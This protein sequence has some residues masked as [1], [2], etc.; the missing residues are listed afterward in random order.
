MLRRTN[1]FSNVQSTYSYHSLEHWFP[2]N[3]NGT[4][5]SS[6]TAGA[7]PPKKHGPPPKWKMVIVVT[8][9][10]YTQTLWIPK[11]TKAIFPKAYEN[12]NVK[13]YAM[14]LLNTFLVVSLVT[15][16][17]FPITTRLLAFWLFPHENYYDKV[18]ELIPK[19]EILS[20]IMKK[21]HH[22]SDR[23]QASLPSSPTK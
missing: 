16:I 13:I 22:K 11:V 19:S 18:K 21:F 2:S 7:N 17:L 12:L 9:V 6:S 3:I 10:I 8:T 23:Q 1:E 20:D 14:G 5:P 4:N 15:Y